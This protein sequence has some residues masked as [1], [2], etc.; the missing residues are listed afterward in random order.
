MCVYIYYTIYIYMSYLTHTFKKI[1]LLKKFT[2]C[3]K[4]STNKVL[5]K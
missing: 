4:I 1:W 2:E 5:V 3:C